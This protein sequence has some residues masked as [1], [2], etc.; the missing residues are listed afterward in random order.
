MYVYLSL[1][2]GFSD[3]FNPNHGSP[4]IH[5]QIYVEVTARRNDDS[6]AEQCQVK[7]VEDLKIYKI[8]L[9]ENQSSRFL[10]KHTD[11]ISV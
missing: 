2:D 5:D 6:V 11:L 7:Q 3:D 4:K 1:D 9:H 8:L 10:I